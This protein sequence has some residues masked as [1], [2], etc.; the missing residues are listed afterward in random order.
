MKLKEITI[1]IVLFFALLIPYNSISQIFEEFE[2][3]KEE[4]EE[5]VKKP[6]NIAP[7]I[8]L[9]Q[10]TDFGAFQDSLK[11]DTLLDNYQI[12]N[13]ALKNSIT[14]TFVGNYGTPALNNDFFD[15]NSNVDFL[16]F[17]SREVYLLT[18]AIVQYHN[19]KTPF[20]RLDFGQSGN[21]SVKNETRFNFLHTQNVNPYLN[22]TL[23]INMAKSTGQYIAQ[24]SKNNFITLYTSYNRDNLNVYAGFITNTVKN[25]ENGGITNDSLLLE[26]P[27]SELI[28]TNLE[29]STTNLKGT[30]YYVNGEYRF[31]KIIETEKD[32]G[33]FRPIFG[34]YVG[35]QYERHQQKFSDEEEAKNTFFEN[36]YYDD[37]YITDS[38]RFNK[39]DNVIQLKQYENAERKTSFGKRAFLGIDFIN[40]TTPGRDSARTA[41]LD[42]N[43]YE[44]IVKN[45]SNLYVGGGIFRE[46]GKFWTWD[47]DGKIY[48][49]GQKAGQTEL[50]GT[51]SKPFKVLKDSAA[52]LVIGGFINN[53][54]ADYFQEEFYS[55][56]FRWNN[57]FNMEQRM[58]V[59]GSIISPRFKL[60]LTGNYAI[61]NNFIYNNYEGIPSQTNKELLVLSAFADKD[62]NYRNLHF[63]VRAL[64]QKASNEE[65]IHLPDF[66]GFVSAYYKFVISKVMF[67]QIG[68]DTRYNT[69]YYA[70][71]YSP[72]TGLFYL[73]NEKKYG[74]YPYIDV[75]ANLRLKRTI[76]FFKMVNIGTGFLN[77]EYMTTAHYPMPRSSFRFGISWLF[78]D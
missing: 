16:F 22:F 10:I 65:F 68:F 66:S 39:I 46:K 57:N 8:R 5:E 42:T 23:Q 70:D 53:K 49:I 43:R 56:H 20:T 28:N 33:L 18:P 25:N 34:I 61:I 48:L 27:K 73:Q 40:T 77:G 71:A 24:E 37:A 17:Q 38:I 60:K 36:T 14:S 35:S 47:F 12:Y 11:L 31:G 4:S 21:K 30:Y 62:F 15:R 32:S 52:S 3:D 7:G 69:M 54:A 1:S 13:P 78:Y 2:V 29:A 9:W 19:T 55:N 59:N 75:Y 63:R 72:S 51:I 44:S 58:D 50:S 6:S 45:Y 26:V 41:G 67:T 76:V 64:W 74:N